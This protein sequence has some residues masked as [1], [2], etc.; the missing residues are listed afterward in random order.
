MFIIS[1][2][3]IYKKNSHYSYCVHNFGV[4]Y[5]HTGWDKRSTHRPRL[6]VSKMM[7]DYK[8]KIEC[9][10]SLLVKIHYMCYS[11]CADVAERVA[12]WKRM[13]LRESSISYL[14]DTY[15]RDRDIVKEFE[16]AAK[17]GHY[18]FTELDD[19]AGV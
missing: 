6:E 11:H 3:L 13:K 17:M 7:K 9:D 4:Y 12:K 15:K 18:D 8:I 2:Y 1:Q 19:L 5:I 16:E 10:P 14:R